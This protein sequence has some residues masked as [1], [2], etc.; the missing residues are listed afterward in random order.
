MLETLVWSF[1]KEESAFPLGDQG[2]MI[3]EKRAR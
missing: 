1:V 2:R 3:Q